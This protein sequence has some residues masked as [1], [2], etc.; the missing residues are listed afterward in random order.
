MAFF[1]Q[2]ANETKGLCFVDKVLWILFCNEIILKVEQKN[3]MAIF[4]K[5]YYFQFT[6]L[7]FLEMMFCIVI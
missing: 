1:V 7:N 6:E 3:V 2:V 4:K 5:Y